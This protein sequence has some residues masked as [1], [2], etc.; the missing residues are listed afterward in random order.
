M[1][2]SAAWATGNTIRCC[3]VFVATSEHSMARRKY[4]RVRRPRGLRR[5]RKR[6]SSRVAK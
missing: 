2:L 3:N 1:V 5:Y 4:S 6:G